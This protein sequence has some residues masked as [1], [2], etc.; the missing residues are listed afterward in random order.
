MFHVACK[1]GLATKV[2]AFVVSL[3][4]MGKSMLKWSCSPVWEKAVYS[5]SVLDIAI[6]CCLFESKKPGSNLDTCNTT[7]WSFV[8]D[9]TSPIR[10]CKPLNL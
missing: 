9:I 7:H 2:A 4:T 10:I 8:I 5:G 3:K 1:T 6:T